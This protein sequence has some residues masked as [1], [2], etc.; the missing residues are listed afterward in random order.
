[1]CD[2]V[3]PNPPIDWICDF[4]KSVNQGLRITCSACN[5][6]RCWQ[7]EGPTYV[8]PA[9]VDSHEYDYEEFDHP[10]VIDDEDLVDG[11]I[12]D[13]YENESEEISDL[14]NDPE[15]Q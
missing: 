14:E 6:I 15:N 5:E 13:E 11:E 9:Y 8:E 4:C 10:M 2:S 7:N 1:M 12:E 3:N